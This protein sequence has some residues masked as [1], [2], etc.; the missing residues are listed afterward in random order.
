[1]CRVD[2]EVWVSPT[3]LALALSGGP[4]SEVQQEVAEGYVI[5]ETNYRVR[6]QPLVQFA[7]MPV[8][9]R[10][11]YQKQQDPLQQYSPAWI[12]FFSSGSQQ[13]T[14]RDACHLAYTCINSPG[15][16]CVLAAADAMY[17]PVYIKGLLS[18]SWTV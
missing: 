17:A 6:L 18:L 11:R 10:C 4:S 1:M 5:V 16:G 14:C 13:C 7:Y 12:R 9:I 8:N 15:F 2:G 3:R